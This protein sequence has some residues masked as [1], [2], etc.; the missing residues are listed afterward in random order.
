MNSS[1]FRSHYFH[2]TSH[3]FYGLL[4]FFFTSILSTPSAI[5]SSSSITMTP[6]EQTVCAVNQDSGSISLWN[7]KR[8]EKPVEIP[9]GVEPRTITVSSDEK[10]AFVTTQRS[11]ELVIVDLIARKS[12]S[13]IPLGGQPVGVVL[14]QD[15]QYAFV[16]QYSGAY[17]KGTYH[18]GVVSV[19]DLNKQTVIKQIPVK[20]Q[21]YAMVCSSD[22]KKIYITHYFQIDNVAW[23]SEIDIKTFQVTREFSFKEAPEISSGKGGVFNALA[24]MDIHPDGKHLLVAGMHANI[25]RGMSQSGRPLSHKTTVQAAVRMVDLKTGS[26]MKNA[27][28]VSSFSGQAVAVPSALAFLPDGKHFLDIYF[29]SQD[30]KTLAYNES[31]EVAERALFSLPAGPTGVVITK[32]GQN[33]FV[34]C[35]WSRSIAHLS[36]KNIRKP[37]LVNN[38]IITKEPWDDQTITGAKIF[39]NTRDSRM[40]PNR[41]LSC[42]TCHLDGGILSDSLLWEFTE[43]HKPSSPNLINTKSLA[44]TFWSGPP[45]LIKGTYQSIHEEDKFVRSFLGGKGFLKSDKNKESYFPENP[46]GKSIE[47][48]AISKYVLSLRPRPNPHMNGNKPRPEISDSV[49]RGRKLFYSHRLGCSRC[50][51]GQYLTRSGLETKIQLADVGTGIKADV[52]SL[53]NLWETG[54]YLHDGRAKTLQ[55]VVTRYNPENKHGKTSHLTVQETNDLVNFLIAPF[56]KTVSQTEK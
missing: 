18:P 38:K 5:A 36:L 12:I 34:N 29:A 9:V 19:I 16:T 33:A 24:G 54:P 52:P 39:H 10:R 42:G 26:E 51:R 27:R 8:D 53:L 25:H 22:G 17:I 2:K 56:V 31:G 45:Y 32:N 23:V 41:W 35:R 46:H 20:A 30:M 44:V 13:R 28:M 11:Q 40:T 15:N 6:N 3:C 21:P 48:D 47:L 55:E 4:T 14:T 37:L 7:W 50:H 49:E 1:P 43:K